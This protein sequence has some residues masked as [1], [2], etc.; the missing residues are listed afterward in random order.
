MVLTNN[1][2][3]RLMSDLI[4][5]Y[6]PPPT[7][8]W[9]S[10]RGSIMM[11]RKSPFFEI[12]SKDIPSEDLSVLDVALDKGVLIEVKNDARFAG[13]TDD[14]YIL[15]LNIAHV[16]R[17]FLRPMTAAKDIVRLE[18]LL[19]IESEGRNRPEFVERINHAL[20]RAKAS[21]SVSEVMYGA[22]STEGSSASSSD[23]AKL[24]QLEGVVFEM[25]ND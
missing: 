20:S 11:S 1:L 17:F 19:A 15:S 4:R 3:E 18:R 21:R 2:E 14:N 23:M 9:A 24:P 7:P 25:E 8:F 22:I 12:R 10:P 5:L 13:M 16:H 6:L